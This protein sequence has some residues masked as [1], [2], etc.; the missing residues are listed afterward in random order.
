MAEVAGAERRAEGSAPARREQVPSDAGR[1]ATTTGPG[2]VAVT[3]SLG[4]LAV[5]AKSTVGATTDPQ[6][7]EADAVADHVMRRATDDK[8]PEPVASGPPVIRRQSEESAASD[9]GGTASERVQSLIDASTGLGRPLP[10]Q[11]RIH[12][13]SA[14]S[15][16]FG[17]VRVH[18]DAA[19]NEAAAALRAVAFTR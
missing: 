9:E 17:D 7:R 11:A 1:M 14:F 4:Q 3:P 5:Q 8:K 19:A 13:E 12:F 16:D 18:D 10:P 15:R 2:G 6:E